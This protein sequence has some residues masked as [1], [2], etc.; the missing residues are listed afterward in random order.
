MHE[1][2]VVNRLRDG[3]DALELVKHSVNL[4]PGDLGVVT[5]LTQALQPAASLVLVSPRKYLVERLAI[6]AAYWD[7]ALMEQLYGSGE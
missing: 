3:V 4:L 2:R 7:A 1:S 5:S 6:E